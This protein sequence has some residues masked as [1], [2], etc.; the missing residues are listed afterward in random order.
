MTCY[1]RLRCLRSTAAGTFCAVS[2]G[3]AFAVLTGL[4]ALFHEL[5]GGGLDAR[6]PIHRRHAPGEIR[7]ADVRA[8]IVTVGRRSLDKPL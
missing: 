1:A 8:G 7:P 2:K 6:A 4:A 3:V 5:G